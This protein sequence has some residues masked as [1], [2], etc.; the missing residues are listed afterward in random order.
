MQMRVIHVQLHGL[1][2]QWEVSYLKPANVRQEC[3][4]L[5]PKCISGAQEGE[6]S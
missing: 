5:V 6:G 3:S 1:I 4:T 2:A